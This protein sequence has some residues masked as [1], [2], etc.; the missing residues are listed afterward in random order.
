MQNTTLDGGTHAT[1]G[2]A[3]VD[4]ELGVEGFS[5]SDLYR[6]GRLRDLAARFYEEVA[7][8][9][10]A[11]HDSL[12][13]YLAA[14]GENLR[15]TKQESELL[16]ASAKHL[17]R[18]VARLF[19]VGREREAHA[20]SILAQS[21]VFEFKTFVARR[22]VKRVP[23]ERA[24]TLDVDAVHAALDALRRS[25]FADTL[26]ADDELGVALMTTR[27]LAWEKLAEKGEAAGVVAVARNIERARAAAE[28]AGVALA[29]FEG[30]ADEKAAGH[31]AGV[32][33]GGA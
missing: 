3:G 21:A 24:L 29:E 10:A 9:D 7:R 12:R 33:E 23:A 17:S 2:A 30:A 28:G 20:A 1:A 25:A 4:F 15:G 8:E 16:I 31:A 19:N 13:N 22:A 18:F 14:R 11:L 6:P 26:A 32:D 27:L 5:Y